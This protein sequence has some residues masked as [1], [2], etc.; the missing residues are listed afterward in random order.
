VV[1]LLDRAGDPS[2]ALRTKKQPV[3]APL[4]H[5]GL[6]AARAADL[7][8]TPDAALGLTRRKRGKSFAYYD[9]HGQEVKDQR[10]LA[11]IAALAI[12]PAWK[13]VWICPLAHGHIQA[14]GR[15]A[16]G[17]KQ[18]KYHARFRALR[19]AAKYDHIVRFGE[20]LPRL[21]RQLRRDLDRAGLD[22]TRVLSAVVEIMQRTC[23]RVGNDRYAQTN[24][25]YGLTTLQDRHTHIRGPELRFKFRGKSGKQHEVALNDAKLARI[26]RRCRDVPGQRL[27]QYEGEDGH[28]HAL[29]SSD[30]NDYLRSVTGEPFSAKDFRTWAGTLLA[31]RALSAT[32][33]CK[34]LSAGRR[35]VK[36]ALEQVSAELGN[37]AAICRKSYVH[38]AAIDQYSCGELH[39]AVE[40]ATTL[41]RRQ[42]LRGLS[43][44]EAITLHWL[45]ALPRLPLQAPPVTRKTAP[46]KRAPA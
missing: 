4:L 40:R 46:R 39:A 22:R 16:K 21:R 42:P 17:R 43:L 31:V 23:V 12:P 14:T 41:A 36:R 37:T 19:D 33:P 44:A 26:V 13:D 38:P 25:S 7:T 30:V 27:F 45:K 29:T 6:A 15:D 8:Y 35:A 1:A 11:R 10:T 2:R 9:A 20:R 24:G 32:E 34:S 18:Y 3:L 28:Y 5:D